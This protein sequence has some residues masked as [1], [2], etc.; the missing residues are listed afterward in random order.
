[1]KKTSLLLLFFAIICAALY[2]GPIA[3]GLDST[4]EIEDFLSKGFSMRY[5]DEDTIIVTPPKSRIGLYD[6]DISEFALMSPDGADKWMA[7]IL[8]FR[9]STSYSTAY[10]FI[11]RNYGEG[12]NRE[13]TEFFVERYSKEP[14]D[15]VIL[16]KLLSGELGKYFLNMLVAELINE[17]IGYEDI[18]DMNMWITDDL[19]ILT[20]G[21]SSN[22]GRPAAIFI[23]TDTIND[24]VNSI[25]GSAFVSELLDL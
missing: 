2:S 24:Y 14:S 4:S 1:M 9:R 17:I 11:S 10:K 20:A 7:A 18:K 13:S 12:L 6:K 23:R 8:E 22:T 5:E 15:E 16:A 3:Y 21:P 25:L 19:Y